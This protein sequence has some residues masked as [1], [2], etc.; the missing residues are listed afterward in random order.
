MDAPGLHVEHHGAPDGLSVVLVHGSPDRSSAFRPVLGLLG[1]LHVVTYDR[2]GWGRSIEAGPPRDLAEHAEDLLAIVDRLPGPVVVVAHS[3]GAHV[4]MVAST[5]RPAA[6]GAIGLWE[7]PLLYEPWWESVLERYGVDALGGTDPAD[8]MEKALRAV[9][10][11]EAVDAWPVEVREARRA[12]GIAYR[13]DMASLLEAPCACEE[14]KVPATAGGGAA[15]SSSS[16]KVAL[17]LA[18]RLPDAQ[19]YVIEG[20]GHFANRTHP[21]AFAGFVRAS[22]ARVPS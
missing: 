19:P 16:R 21:E 7:P 20:V 6:F 8:E 22:V 10:G 1:D 5:V 18:E 17:W 9:L 11:D 12:E 13:V 2:R 4:T 14:V 3:F 15:S